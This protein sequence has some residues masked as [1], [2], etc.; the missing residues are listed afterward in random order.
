MMSNSTY[1]PSLGFLNIRD[2]EPYRHFE[3]RMVSLILQHRLT[4]Y[5]ARLLLSRIDVEMSME[6]DQEPYSY[7]HYI[8]KINYYQDELMAATKSEVHH[9]IDIA[10]G[11]IPIDLDDDD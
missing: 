5:Q 10:D 3:H 9:L 11:Q 6:Y 8:R 2:H 4:E 7:D 1:K